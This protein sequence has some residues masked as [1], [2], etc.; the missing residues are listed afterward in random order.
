MRT[1]S[2]AISAIAAVLYTAIFLAVG[3]FAINPGVGEGADLDPTS[4]RYRAGDFID[5]QVVPILALPF[6]PYTVV[7]KLLH[8]RTGPWDYVIGPI[9]VCLLF[10]LL[11]SC[12]RHAFKRPTSA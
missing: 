3:A 5:H 8:F 6:V 10:W 12:F 9:S 4:F 2:L 11:L 1:N 7:R